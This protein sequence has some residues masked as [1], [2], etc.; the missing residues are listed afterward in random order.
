[1]HQLAGH[2]L[3]MQSRAAAETKSST[4]ECETSCPVDY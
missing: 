3:Q 1:M 2:Y 4:A